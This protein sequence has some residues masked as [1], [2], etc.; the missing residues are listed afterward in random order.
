MGLR[1]D[2]QQP[3]HVDAVDSEHGEAIKRHA[4]DEVEI[5]LAHPLHR[6]VMVEMLGIDIGDDRDR[7]EQE[8]KG[9]V[10]LVGLG[11][12]VVAAAKAHVGAACAQISA[13]RH[14]R[15]EASFLEDKPDQ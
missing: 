5:G 2:A 15:I 7:R 11:H 4:V 12:H 3:A 10:A 14:R 1:T 8:Q 13:D 6:A 9:G